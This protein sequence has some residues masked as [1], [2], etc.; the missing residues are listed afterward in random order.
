M[1]D[2]TTVTFAREDSLVTARIDGP[3]LPVPAP[4]P[5]KVG[6]VP[7]ISAALE[8]RGLSC[9]LEQGISETFILAPL[10]D[11]RNLL[12]T[13]PQEPAE[14]QPPGAWL[15]MALRE[16]DA[17]CEM[18]WDSETTGPDH[19]HLGIGPLLAAVDRRLDGL[20]VV[21]RPDPRP[22]L[23][24][25]GAHPSLY[26]AGFVPVELPTGRFHR[27]PLGMTD[28]DEQRGAVT[29]AIGSLRFEGFEVQCPPELLTEDPRA[30]HATRA[31]DFGVDHLAAF[32]SDHARH[33]RDVVAA[34]DEIASPLDGTL[35][36]AVA[37]LHAA[38]D[39]W[40]HLGG[41]DAERHLYRLHLMAT[42]IDRRTVEVRTLRGE[43]ADRHT[44]KPPGPRAGAP[45]PPGRDS[46]RAQAAR[47]TSPSARHTP[48]TG[49]PP[50]AQPPASQTSPRP[51][52]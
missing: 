5:Y 50:A 13:P 17:G 33:T 20:G 1:L 8:S 12:I 34:L 44:A 3:R 42:E 46:S 43:L 24:E 19:A 18:W 35:A 45:A 31:R 32:V 41:P 47:A 2:R 39:W 14:E 27:L 52:R 49:T 21:P 16:S 26:R 25:A 6:W 9:G 48:S 36:Q 23:N 7:R 15:A 40:Q 51:R 29:R 10:P 4:P 37:A 38:A 22:V 28:H 11:G 30:H